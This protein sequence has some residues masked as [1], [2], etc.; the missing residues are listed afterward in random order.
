MS[1]RQIAKELNLYPMN[2]K[3]VFDMYKSSGSIFDKHRSDRPPKFNDKDK[4]K[5]IREVKKDKTITI[6]Q[7]KANIKLDISGQTISNIL[8]NEGLESKYVSRGFT[9]SEN[10]I[11]GRKLF[12]ITNLNKK[13][14]FWNSILWSDE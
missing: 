6:P 5:I 14:G 7:I 2:V 8:K 10:A 9:L 1:I 13:I 4:R 11:R 12:Y 3:R